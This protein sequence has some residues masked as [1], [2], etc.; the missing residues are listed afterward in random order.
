MADDQ[1]KD[2][3]HKD[4]DPF[5]E[6]ARIVGFDEGEK[7]ATE[8][9]EPAPAVEPVAV[10]P[11][12]P[13]PVSPTEPVSVPPPTV[14]IPSPGA[15]RAPTPTVSVASPNPGVEAAPVAAPAPPA[16]PAAEPLAPSLGSS[17]S[18][19]PT[20][21]APVSPPVQAE[22]V[23]PVRPTEPSWL[24][25]VADPDPTPDQE[26]DG[27]LDLE[28]ELLRELEIGV[29]DHNAEEA[30]LAQAEAPVV[31]PQQD[32]GPS[33]FDPPAPPVA[34]AE[35][36][37]TEPV[38]PIAEPKAQVAELVEPA[39]PVVES[40]EPPIEA[41][42]PATDPLASVT[43]PVAPAVDPV[44]PI[45]EATPAE[46]PKPAGISAAEEDRLNALLG[47]ALGPV[48]P[49]EEKS[50]GSTATGGGVPLQG[51]DW[52]SAE[53]TPEPAVSSLEAELEAAFTALED[54]GP[55]TEKTNADAVTAE[56]AAV[57][58]PGETVA[59]S[60]E[61]ASAYR[62]FEE[63]VQA[64]MPKATPLPEA[65]ESD[66][67]DSLNDAL[68]AEMADV[69]AEAA[70]AAAP[71][72]APDVPF[73]HASINESDDVPEAMAE[74]DVPTID[75]QETVPAP[76]AEADFGLPLEEELEALA[77]EAAEA[78]KD[79]EPPTDPVDEIPLGP[80]I[81]VS[82]APGPEAPVSDELMGGDPA[83]AAALTPEEFAEQGADLGED[84]GFQID[85]DLLVPEFDNV[86]EAEQSGSG[87]RGLV[88][89]MVVLG[90]AV[91]G[92]GGFYLWNSNLGGDSASTV[93]PVIT[94]DN[95]PVKVKPENPGGKTVPNQDLAVYDRVSGNET[96]S[97]QEQNLV[98]TTEEPVDV[99]QRT[100]QPGL[101]PLEGRE[102]AADPLVKS[103]ER[104]SASNTSDDGSN[105]TEE[106]VAVAPRKVRTLVVKPDGT[107]VAR[108]LPAATETP[109][110]GATDSGS[111]ESNQPT[112]VSTQQDSAASASAPSNEVTA[113]NNA[114]TTSSAGNG[115][116]RQISLTPTQDT[117][118]DSST[119]SGDTAATTGTPTDTASST[120]ATRNA[121]ASDSNAGP[122]PIDENLRDTGQL[123]IPV[124]NPSRT[125][126]STEVA[127]VTTSSGT[128]NSNANAPV[129]SA[130][131]AEQPVTIVEAVN[132]RG[133]LV[134][135]QAAA[136]GA[137][138]MQI[139]SQPSEA[140][141]RE[142]YQNLSR[143]Y[144]SI[145]GGRG[146]NIQRADIPNKGV[147][148]RVRIPVGSKNDATALCNQYK[149]A[150]GSCFVAR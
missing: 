6:L 49:A 70:A 121:S 26:D 79:A 108:E 45:S 19:M 17:P 129:P 111:S 22:A 96:Q 18:G 66:V 80:E 23:D 52:P 128:A 115:Q 64:A 138:S 24:N 122:P 35:P 119:N 82:A 130:R 137:Y 147:F 106:T 97:A 72:P 83:H 43:E 110:T 84:D 95:E 1:I 105:S 55:E 98:T 77:S 15:Y 141:A 93:T 68:L 38:S 3:R 14:N 59:E 4:D 127:A 144:T 113:S 150:G 109:V 31:R 12:A 133:N 76:S 10:P 56:I 41:A 116:P 39:V 118:A 62:K 57:V 146:V 143:R 73:D 30:R 132:Q 123:P 25:P 60:Q 46:A 89:A 58:P 107:I 28:A 136:P 140:G 61:L 102:D 20:A 29:A 87:R 92:G 54:S 86:A 145:I 114:D 67:T 34:E 32:S 65:S 63:D 8:E 148:Y 40:A 120:D 124:N 11:V 47:E 103:E 48:P 42:M 7:K 135:S 69:E 33:F 21:G 9:A 51:G 104:L 53:P 88:A 131:P 90:V 37:V 13:L 112:V 74:L 142:S 125:E 5:A 91:V 100:L 44:D 36:P 85:E 27:G 2:P 149:A 81:D 134:D 78:T 71:P 139:S 126:S 75:P 50:Q 99:V 101:L 16:V 94:A 117:T